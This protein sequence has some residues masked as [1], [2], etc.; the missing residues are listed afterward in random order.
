MRPRRLA[1]ALLCGAALIASGGLLRRALVPAH[2][3]PSPPPPVAALLGGEDTAGFE[4]AMVPRPFR[5]PEDHGPHPEFRHEWWYFTGNLRTPE[6]RR[7]GYQ[8]TFFRFALSPPGSAARE[9]R[10]AATQVYMAHFALTDV[11][12]NRFRFFERTGRGA[13]GLAGA[14][15][16]PFHVWIDDWSAEGGTGSVLPVRL[17][18]LE[19]GVSIDLLL[20]SGK[21]VVPQGDRGLSRKGP[22]PGNASH[23]YSITRLATRG[24]VRLD[25]RTFPVE[26]T[27][28][29]DREWGT[30]ALG[31][32][33]AG[34]DWFAL[35]LS[36]GSDLMFYRLRRTGGGA[37]PYSAGTLILPDGSG[38]RLSPEDVRIDALDSWVSP[39]G[40]ARYPSRW[41][42]RLPSEELELEVVPL[43]ANQELRASVR[44]WEG[45]V[46]VG[47]TAR[48]KT[49]AGEG[50]VELTGY[51]ET[52][53]R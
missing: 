2:A 16:K 38:K 36:D 24:N 51:G 26:G 27:S 46:S 47:G 39:E 19:G 8:L 20:D 40:G 17:R 35:H 22:E 42:L 50:Y 44:Y 53:G 6:G 31:K 43:V 32:E 12:G 37:D 29:L 11:S 28:W 48:G 1:I 21:P 7:F 9:S 33:Q 5:F 10:W 3:P 34:W 4:K 23:Y 52:N 13:L 49:I 25:G 30:S 15:A 14:S 41:K 45:A 18:A